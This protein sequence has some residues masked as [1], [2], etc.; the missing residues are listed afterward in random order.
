MRRLYLLLSWLVVV[1][2]AFDA[3]LGVWTYNGGTIAARLFLTAIV[4]AILA[5][6]VWLGDAYEG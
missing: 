2:L 3:L 4:V 6:V 5:V 1:I